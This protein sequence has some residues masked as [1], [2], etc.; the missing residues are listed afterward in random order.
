MQA[1]RLKIK[2]F[3]GVVTVPVKKDSYDHDFRI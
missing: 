1:Y 2:L 3:E